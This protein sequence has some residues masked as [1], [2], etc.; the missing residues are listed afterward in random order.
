MREKRILK[1]CMCIIASII[2]LGINSKSSAQTTEVIL[3]QINSSEQN[4][5]SIVLQEDITGNI[6]IPQGKSVTIDLNG[7]TWTTQTSSGG[8]GIINNC[9][10]SCSISFIL[11]STM[12]IGL[13]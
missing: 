5:I 6:E 2:F 12:F 11:D 3:N 1:L 8:R 13:S 4:E 10:F 7:H 9:S